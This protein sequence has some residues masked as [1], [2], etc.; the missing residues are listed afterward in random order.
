M[1]QPNVFLS[2]LVI[3]LLVALAGA[4]KK[5]PPI[6]EPEVP[7]E[8]PA[9]PPPPPEPPTQQVEPDFPAEPIQEPEPS[10]SELIDR[11]N[12]EGVVQTIYFAF[13]SSELS[14]TSRRTLAANAD[15]LKA[16][17]DVKLV[18]EGHCDERGTIEYN[19]AL[20]ER[21]AS[22]VR[23]YL[24]SLGLDRG[25]MRIITYGEER[26]AQPGHSESAWSKNRRAAFLLEP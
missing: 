6:T 11:W 9:P 18:V 19:L 1:R 23:D 16:H 20:G 24:S 21:R 10:R 4:C 8:E 22:A 12:R 25:R 2:I 15:W 14:E 17:A 7:A 26:P 13:D 5:A 3:V